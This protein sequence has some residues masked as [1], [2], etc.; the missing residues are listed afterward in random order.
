MQLRIATRASEQAVAQTSHV[1]GRLRER[2]HEVELV[3]VSTQGDRDR[4]TPLH[5]LGG[6]GIFTKEV[7]LAVLDGRAD[8]AVHSA[9]DLP[10]SLTT[11][12][13]RLACVPARHDARD[14][15]VGC[16]FA[17]LP[18]GATVATGSVRRQAQLSAL[19]PDLHFVGLR[20]NIPTRVA[21]ADDPDVD[22][23]L[24][25]LAGVQWVGLE[26]R[27]ASMFSVDQMVPQ[28]GQGALALE[29][30]VDADEI[31]DA[32]RELQHEP[33]RRAVDTERAFLA[34]LG[35]GCDVP[36][37][38]HAFIRPD[39]LI[40]I[41]GVIATDL[42]PGVVPDIARGTLVGDTP[43]VGVALANMLRR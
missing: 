42:Q 4:T 14:A 8:I 7:Q 27:I 3:T 39:G 16:A 9:K 30:L 28:V 19:R 21:R 38:A 37:G 13:L 22:A 43:M 34:R 15:L 26:H 32:L 17:D 6:R 18:T 41:T 12:G 23:S 33:S 10:A 25:A 40:E 31:S 11:E 35:G 1:A 20:G 36:V 24:V 29:C 2:G 5:E